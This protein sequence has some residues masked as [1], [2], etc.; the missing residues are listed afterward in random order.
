[1]PT[2]SVG[3]RWS[4]SLVVMF[5]LDRASTGIF[6]SKTFNFNVS[7]DRTVRRARSFR[8]VRGKDGRGFCMVDAGQIGAALSPSFPRAHRNRRIEGLSLDHQWDRARGRCHVS[9]YGWR[10]VYFPFWWSLWDGKF[11]RRQKSDRK[12]Q[13]RSTV[14]RSHVFEHRETSCD[15]MYVC[16]LCT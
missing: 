15:L 5:P 9:L 14:G 4:P 2:C 12:L 10:A 3:H 7:E 11:H 8:A 6:C 13:R 16:R 1:M